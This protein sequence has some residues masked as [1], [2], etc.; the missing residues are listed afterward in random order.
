MPK[1]IGA[2]DLR[3]RITVFDLPRDETGEVLRDADGYPV[4]EPVNVFGPGGGRSCKWE[5]AWGS[6]V[7]AARQA[8]V[9]DPATLT[10][11][12]TP[13]ITT[14]STVFRGRDPRPYEVIS[15]RDIGDRHAWMEVKVQRK[16]A[17][18]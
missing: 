10:L 7:Y 13:K 5:D 18:K 1:Q 14:T 3:T 4:Q 2:G 8:G 16:E 9:T 17:A 6:E 12:Y 15:V 11:R